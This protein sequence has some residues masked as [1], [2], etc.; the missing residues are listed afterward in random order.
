MRLRFWL[1]AIAVV[2]LAAGSVVAAILVR[3]NET[4]HFH[5]LQRDE[6]L[7]SAHQAETVAQL[8]VGELTSAA[9]F[10]EAQRDL[11]RHDFKIVGDSLLRRGAL[12]AT[13]FIQQVT[14]AERPAFELRH[15]FPIVELGLGGPVPASKRPVYF[16]VAFAVAEQHQKTVP[17]GYD[18]GSD[19]VRGPALRRAR[20]SGHAA[21]TRVMPLLIGGSGI[22]VYRPVYRDGSPLATVAERRR[23]LIG[24]AAGA[25]RIHDLAAA[26][27]SAVPASVDVQIRVGGMPVIGEKGTFDDTAQASIPVAD[28]TWQVVVHDPAGPDIALPLLI[29]V[30][31]VALAALLGALV[32]VW[33][34]NERMRELQRQASQDPLTGLKNRRRFEEDL[35]AELARS[36]REGTNGA[37]LMLDLDHFK[38]V[39]DTLGHPVGDLVLEEVAG[40]LARRT[41]ETDVLARV[42]GDEFAIV[43]PRCDAE[44]AQ[45][46][47]EM[48][49]TAVREHVP[50]SE[51]VPQ[52]NVSVGVAIFGAGTG[53]TFESILIDADSAMYAAKGDGGDGVRLSG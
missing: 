26:A 50:A 3:A 22:N 41:R 20:D 47:A 21:A 33:S 53:A 24:F 45:T 51:D 18:I 37:V 15:D 46:V 48:I 27:I 34:R 23:A 12:T 19:P 7:R 49:G 43:L 31:G 42:G 52:L 39:N 14:L 29:A 9:A 4:D 32:L 36:K 28:R 5:T 13:A 16:P 11:N 35:R 17:Q 10:F 30:V 25:F 2:L 6:A 1:G 8:S 38:R 40:V 44:Q